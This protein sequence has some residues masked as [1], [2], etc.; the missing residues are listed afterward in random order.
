MW[1]VCACGG[2]SQ[3]DAARGQTES[4]SD[5]VRVHKEKK[6]CGEYGSARK[7]LFSADTGETLHCWYA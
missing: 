4:G 1:R 7:P 2:G 6:K 5:G 3:T